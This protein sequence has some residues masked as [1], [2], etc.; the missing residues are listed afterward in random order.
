MR[1]LNSRIMPGSS[2]NSDTVR[3]PANMIKAWDMKLGEMESK[4]TVLSVLRRGVQNTAS[5][6]IESFGLRYVWAAAC[7][8][9]QLAN[10]SA[11]CCEVID[12]VDS[13]DNKPEASLRLM[14]LTA[15]F[16][17]PCAAYPVVRRATPEPSPE[18]P[19]PTTGM[20]DSAAAGS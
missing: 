8:S 19:V 13:V 20:A 2:L 10:Y 15:T 17:E 14:P 18:I 5:R 4:A 7:G 3:L 9:M 1:S 6:W 11:P 16:A 12:N